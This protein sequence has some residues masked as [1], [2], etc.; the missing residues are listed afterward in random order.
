MG[1]AEIMLAGAVALLEPKTEEEVYEWAEANLVLSSN[2]TSRPGALRLHA[3]QKGEWSPLWA[4]RRYSDILKLAATQ[5]GKTLEE[6]I[7]VAYATACAPGPGMMVFPNE[8]LARRRSKKHL[9]PFL[10]ECL[11]HLI[12][13]NKHDMGLFE[14]LF[15]HGMTVNLAHS[16]SPAALAGE[17]IKY[18]W[19]DE[20]AKFAP[21]TAKEA[22]AEHN[23]RERTKSFWPFHK[24]W[25]STTPTLPTEPGWRSW[26]GSTQCTFQVPCKDCGER[27]TLY[28]GEVDRRIIEPQAEGEYPG[29]VRWDRDPELTLAERLASAYY[30]CAHC[31]S[32][33]NDYEL[34][35]AIDAGAWKPRHKNAERYGSWVNSLVSPSIRMRDML[36]MWFASYKNTD[37]RRTFYNSWLGVYYKESGQCAEEKVLRERILLGHGRGM[38]PADAVAV[39]MTVDVHDDHLRYRVRA[40]GVDGTSWGVE[41]GQTMREFEFLEPIMTRA[42]LA[43]DGTQRLID[44]V[45][46]DCNYRRKEVYQFCLRHPDFCHPISGVPRKLKEAYRFQT[47]AVPADMLHDPPLPLG[48]QVTIVEIDDHQAKNDLFAQVA[49]HPGD[50]G[51]WYLEE[52][53]SD[54]F[55]FQMQGEH[56]IEK[57]TKNGPVGEWVYQHDNHALDCEK[58]QLIAYHVLGVASYEIQ[59]A[60]P[61]PEQSGT[62]YNPYTG[63]EV[64][65]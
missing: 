34:N 51:C 27:Q 53:I 42:Y 13:K 1:V 10:K 24:I 9:Q 20:T 36:K 38:V 21:A 56:R 48:G 45:F 14:Y 5:S 63:K 35:Q 12:S 61:E 29:G 40:W 2:V 8:L 3:H 44:R 59:Q 41:E 54:G 58:Y 62:V 4:W 18:L 39:I 57:I 50:P 26:E 28:F 6:Q 7:T 15:A 16:G 25:N 19:M 47:V 30:Q 49:I 22:G 11:P 32:R 43:A 60:Q 31:D 33:W 65:V 17:P 46:I 55:I 64:R 23:A 52:D 37:D